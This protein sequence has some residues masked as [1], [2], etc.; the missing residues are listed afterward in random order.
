MNGSIYVEGVNSVLS[1]SASSKGTSVVKRVKKLLSLAELERVKRIRVTVAGQGT[2]TLWRTT[3]IRRYW[4][5]DRPHGTPNGAQP[6]LAGVFPPEPEL[7]AESPDQEL[8]TEGV[9][10]QASQPDIR[11]GL[12]RIETDDVIP[13]LRARFSKLLA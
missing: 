13:F 3:M 2:V 10:T 8:A 1:L 6:I 5:E 12:T 9:T 7:A 11:H 4:C